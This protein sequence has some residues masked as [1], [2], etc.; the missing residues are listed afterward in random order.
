MLQVLRFQLQI[1][2]GFTAVAHGWRGAVGALTYPL[3]LQNV[4]SKV[5]QNNVVPQVGSGGKQIEM[6]I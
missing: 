1:P 2:L 4:A 5:N 3:P 6:D